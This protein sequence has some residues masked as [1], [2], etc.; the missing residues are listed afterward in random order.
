MKR[1][2]KVE[3]IS[4]PQKTTEK[5]NYQLALLPKASEQYRHNVIKRH[6]K[7][8]CSMCDEI[9]IVKISTDVGNAWR[10]ERF[11]KQCYS[12]RKRKSH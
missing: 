12:K 9:P 10:V 11:C 1:K 8:L 5:M 6:V 4:I 7:D 2:T 3:N